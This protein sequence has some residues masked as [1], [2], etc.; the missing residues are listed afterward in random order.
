LNRGRNGHRGL[1]LY[2]GTLRRRQKVKKTRLRKSI[3]LIIAFQG[4]NKLPV[5]LSGCDGTT[6][7]GFKADSHANKGGACGFLG[8]FTTRYS[9]NY[10]CEVNA[11]RAAVGRGRGSSLDGT[12][13]ECMSQ[14]RRSPPE[15]FRNTARGIDWGIG[16]RF[17][18]FARSKKRN[19]S[20]G[21]GGYRSTRCVN[22]L[23]PKAN[24]V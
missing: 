18:K 16:I 2:R 11:T 8:P 7:F 9:D 12:S 3:D 19:E 6:G 23:T 13:V 5:T 20:F 1:L 10:T 21:L 17:K 22:K 4:T 14:N 15:L 24:D